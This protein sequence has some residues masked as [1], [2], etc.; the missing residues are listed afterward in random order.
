LGVVRWLRGD[1][2]K[3]TSLGLQFVKGEMQPVMLR[4][5]KGNRIETSWQPALLV[6]G[7]EMHG[8]ASPTVVSQ[9]GLYQDGRP[10][11]LQIGLETLSIRA[12]MRIEATPLIE[13]YFYQ[14]YLH[15]EED[16]QIASGD[17]DHVSL[18]NIPLPGDH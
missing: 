12:R 7:E 14:V 1:K 11:M 13:R 18:D 15:E 4:A 10:L 9:R 2:R 6:S 3:G 8:L 5:R 17:D 16:E